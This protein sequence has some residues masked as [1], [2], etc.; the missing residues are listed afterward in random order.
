MLQ[1]NGWQANGVAEGR[2]AGERSPN[3]EGDILTCPAAY[4]T[5]WDSSYHSQYSRTCPAAYVYGSAAGKGGVGGNLLRTVFLR[6]LGRG[7]RGN[8]LPAAHVTGCGAGWSLRPLQREAKRSE[9]PES[10]RE[11]VREERCPDQATRKGPRDAI[12]RCIK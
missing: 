11:C 7:S 1:S 12:K 3:M 9:G 5:G 6:P 10:R 8:L 4:V 2:P